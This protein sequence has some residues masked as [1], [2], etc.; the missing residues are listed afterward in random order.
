MSRGLVRTS[1]AK[2]IRTI[3]A[4][5]TLPDKRGNTAAIPV[6]EQFLPVSNDDQIHAPAIVA[7]LERV[8]QA[9]DGTRTGA[10]IIAVLAYATDSEQ[11]YRDAENLIEE[12]QTELI[13]DPWLDGGSANLTAP[14]E[15]NIPQEQTFPVFQATLSCG[16]LMPAIQTLVAP[17]GSAVGDL[18]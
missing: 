17:D 12:I 16:V 13:T 14:W 10:V 9:A 7:R 15:T 2:R 6:Y 3:T 4:C 8:S 1:I 18:I 11:G 5:K